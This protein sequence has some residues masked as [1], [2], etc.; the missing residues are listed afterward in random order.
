MSTESVKWRFVFVDQMSGPAK[1]A[2]RNIDAVNRSLRQSQRDEE[3]RARASEAA[4]ARVARAKAQEARATERAAAQARSAS[5]RAQRAQASVVNRAAKQQA[6]ADARA[7]SEQYAA[8]RRYQSA[9]QAARRQEQARDDRAR[10]EGYAAQKRYQAAQRRQVE[11]NTARFQAQNEAALGTL[12]TLAQGAAAAVLG[13]AV[14]FGQITIAIGAA[15]LRLAAFRESTLT[16]LRVLSGNSRGAARRQFGNAITIANQTPDDTEAVA[17]R[18]ANLRVAG[19]SERETTP[20]LAAVGDVQAARGNQAASSAELLLSQFRG[21]GRVDGGDLRQLQAAGVGQGEFLDS[22]ARQLGINNPDDAGR[23]LA[24]RR[25]ISSRRVTG[26][27]GTQAFL[28]SVRNQ[29]NGGGPLGTLA[30]EQSNTLP[31]AISNLSNALPNLALRI[32]SEDLP[33]VQALQRAIVGI[34]GALDTSTA[35]GRRFSAALS[36]LINGSAG[37]IARVFNPEFIV[38]GITRAQAAIATVTPY[39][40]AFTQGFS[41]G[42]SQGLQPMRLVVSILS[43]IA[44]LF[45]SSGANGSQFLLTINLIGRGL[46]VLA[47]LLVTV[48]GFLVAFTGA[49]IAAFAFVTGAVNGTLGALAGLVSYFFTAASNIGTAIKDGLVTGI[50]SLPGRVTDAVSGVAHGAIDSVRDTLGIRSPS[51]VMMELGGRAAEG[52]ALGV[53]GGGL[54]VNNALT[55]LVS[56]PAAQGAGGLRAGGTNVQVYI[57]VQ[58]AT[59]PVE[60]AQ[61]VGDEF[62]ERM[63]ALFGRLAEVSP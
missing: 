22:I 27:Q 46:G 13:I 8:Q 24:A 62:E 26:D 9:Q 39:V 16:T 2:Q 25:A 55:N 36:A 45:S 31:G 43:R 32:A 61:A 47:G 41:G 4:S 35:S 44:G 6:S 5:E 12:G 51:R 3:R 23:R 42:F 33:G 17:A 29:Y 59:N 40:R 63:A 56:P 49:T 14:A 57:T 34:T 38:N 11:A 15:L 60:T 53:D 7:R 37:G 54:S 20:L 18:Q 1:S 48:G 52:F 10:A 21:T 28:D 50:T 30:R 58:G 19:Y